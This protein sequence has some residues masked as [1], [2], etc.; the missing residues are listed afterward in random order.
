MLVDFW[1]PWCRAMF[2]RWPLSR[3]VARQAPGV[4]FIARHRYQPGGLARHFRHPLDPDADPLPGRRRARAT[5]RRALPSSELLRWL[6][7][8]ERRRLTAQGAGLVTILAA[9]QPATTR[10]PLVLPEDSLRPTTRAAG[11]GFLRHQ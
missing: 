6:P 7:A 11:G 9:S 1:A 10:S 3:A 4:R 2:S 8:V 5:S